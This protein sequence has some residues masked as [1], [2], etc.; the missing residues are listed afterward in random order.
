MTDDILTKIEDRILTITFNR[1]DKKNALTAAMYAKMVDAMVDA[2]TNDDVRVILLTGN[3]DA[4]TAGNDL[5]DFRDNPPLGADAPVSRFL[6]ELVHAEKPMIAA[7]N[8][9]AVGVGLT[10]LLHCDLVYMANGAGLQAPF[11]DLALVPE[12]ASSLLLPARVGHARAAEI[13]MLGKTVGADEAVS[14]GLANAALAADELEAAA[15]KA[16]QALAKKAPEAV[17]QSKRLMR[18][19]PEVLLERMNVEGQLFGE[20]LQSPELLEAV[21]AFMQKREPNFG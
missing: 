14:M 21:T 8:G 3:G 4:F 6:R 1:P 9:I 13:F 16:A 17:K 20:R 2:N 5:L 7:V 19:D 12:A 10:M 18:G 11:V 15:L